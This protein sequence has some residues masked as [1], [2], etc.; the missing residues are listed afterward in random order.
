MFYSE[1]R[2]AVFGMQKREKITKVF[3]SNIYIRN[4]KN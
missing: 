1:K 4:T 3:S 2:M